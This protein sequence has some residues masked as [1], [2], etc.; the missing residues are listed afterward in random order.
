M[1]LL[2]NTAT[3]VWLVLVI[4]TGATYWMGERDAG[5]ALDTATVWLVYGLACVKGWLVIDVFMGLRHAPRFWRRVMLGW[6][7]VVTLVLASLVVL[8]R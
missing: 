2:A 5:H 6:L 4:A 3:R 1:K 7:G 8:G